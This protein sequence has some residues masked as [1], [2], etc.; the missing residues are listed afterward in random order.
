LARLTAEHRK[1]LKPSQFAEP[2]ERKYPINDRAHAIAAKAR[3]T[4]HAS[5]SE[6]V[7]IDKKA[8][9]ILGHG[10]ESSEHESKREETREQSVGKRGPGNHHPSAI[11]RDVTRHPNLT[12][13]W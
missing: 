10:K 1:Q 8:D 5:P 11:R 12:R 7:A 3:A 2:A 4:Q 9:K 6:K 13:S